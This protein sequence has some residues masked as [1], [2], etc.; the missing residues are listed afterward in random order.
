MA[1]FDKVFLQLAE[2]ILDKVYF[3][4][5]PFNLVKL[6][7]WLVLRLVS[8]LKK[9]KDFF[10]TVEELETLLR[11]DFTIKAI[12]A[13]MLYSSI[14]FPALLDKL[15]EASEDVKRAYRL[16]KFVAIRQIQDAAEYNIFVT[17]FGDR[18]R[19]SR[20]RFPPP[21][22]P[23]APVDDWFHSVEQVERD[24]PATTSYDALFLPSSEPSQSFRYKKMMSEFDLAATL[25]GVDKV[26]LTKTPLTGFGDDRSFSAFKVE[27][28]ETVRR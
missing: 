17:G 14:V 11:R 5:E 12:N 21:S 2:S 28:T 7:D 26:P 27:I 25:R 23:V 24:A 8:E 6:E 3:K 10:P 18:L 20:F 9:E 4:S 19:A 1:L 22:A 15:T 13:F 16:G